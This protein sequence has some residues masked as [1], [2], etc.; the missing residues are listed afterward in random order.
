MRT[1]DLS[2]NGRQWQD[3]SVSRSE[4]L[5]QPGTQQIMLSIASHVAQRYDHLASYTLSSIFLIITRKIYSVLHT[6][7][8]ILQQEMLHLSVKLVIG[9]SLSVPHISE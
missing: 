5:L 6:S 1:R 3:R 9:T 2:F 4:R 8:C 7:H